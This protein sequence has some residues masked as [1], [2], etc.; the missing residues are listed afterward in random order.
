MAY[1]E[2][3][4]VTWKTLKAKVRPGAVT[5]AANLVLRTL[6][7]SGPGVDVYGIASQLGVKVN[8]VEDP[9]WS[10]AIR[11]EGELAE[12]WLC[13]TDFDV[14][15]RFT[16][17]HELGHLLLHPEG[18]MFRDISFAGDKKESEA[19][20]FAADLLMPLWVL[21][22]YASEPGVGLAELASMFKV[23]TNALSIQLARIGGARILW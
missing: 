15:K 18:R 10:G 16:L 20:Q 19:N 1:S 14:R 7:V 8:E 5:E 12:I 13:Q 21:D 17:A 11:S 22:S 2:A 23:S 6:G 4:R 9:G 3:D